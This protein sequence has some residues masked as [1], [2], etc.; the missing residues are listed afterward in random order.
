MAVMTTIPPKSQAEREAEEKLR[1]IEKAR[2]A[3][4]QENAAAEAAHAQAQA[5]LEQARRETEEVITYAKAKGYVDL[6]HARK[7]LAKEKGQPGPVDA[8]KMTREQFE[9]HKIR[10][11]EEAFAERQR[12]RA[13]GR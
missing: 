9:Q 6:E 13:G 3:A 2:D 1:R 12:R 11:A 10:K 5:E 4:A 7:M 8:F